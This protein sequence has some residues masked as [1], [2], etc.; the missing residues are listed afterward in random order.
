MSRLRRRAGRPGASGAAVARRLRRRSECVVPLCRGCHRAYDRGELDLFPTWS[1]ASARS[2]PTPWS[3]YRWA[4][5][6][7]VRALLRVVVCGLCVLGVIAA[8][9]VYGSS[10]AVTESEAAAEK[11]QARAA[12]DRRAERV[13][14]ALGETRGAAPVCPK[15]AA[16][17]RGA[18]IVVELARGRQTSRRVARAKARRGGAHQEGRRGADGPAL[19]RPSYADELP[20]GRN[21]VR[22][23]QSCEPDPS[24]PPPPQDP[25]PSFISWRG[26][27]CRFATRPLSADRVLEGACQGRPVSRAESPRPVYSRSKASKLAISQRACA[28]LLADTPGFSC[29][30]RAR[31]RDAKPSPRRGAPRSARRRRRPHLGR[32]SSSRRAR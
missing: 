4:V 27:R 7:S 10:R 22:A 13:A 20:A 24:F 16:Q 25:A 29:F 19:L 18:E 32:V 5:A 1:P 9:Y 3:T 12:S 23:T 14:R 2:S 17:A 28:A 26:R 21:S 30:W 15:A 31:R 6:V 8:G 11:R